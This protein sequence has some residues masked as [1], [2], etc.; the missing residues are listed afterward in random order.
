[1]KEKYD[2]NVKKE[3]TSRFVYI[4]KMAGVQFADENAELLQSGARGCPAFLLERRVRHGT[5]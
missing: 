4:V 3:G 5:F 2:K 1:M